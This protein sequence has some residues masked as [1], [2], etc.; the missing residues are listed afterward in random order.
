M[1]RRS[2]KPSRFAS[3]SFMGRGIDGEYVVSMTRR[4]LAGEEGRR[5]ESGIC[6]YA[7]GVLSKA[8]EC[9]K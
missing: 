6:T 4:E 8:S 7:W 3:P 5:S 2:G 1:R 9:K